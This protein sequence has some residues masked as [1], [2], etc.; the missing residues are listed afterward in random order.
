[1]PNSFWHRGAFALLAVTLVTEPAVAELKHM[2][3]GVYGTRNV[4]RGSRAIIEVSQGWFDLVDYTPRLD[5]SRLDAPGHTF[6]ENRSTRVFTTVAHPEPLTSNRVVA[7]CDII[8]STFRVVYRPEDCST[9]RRLALKHAGVGVQRIGVWQSHAHVVIDPVIRNLPSG[10]TATITCGTAVNC[11]PG[12]SRYPGKIYYFRGGQ[13][14]YLDFQVS[15][16]APTGSYVMTLVLEPEGDTRKEVRIPLRISALSPIKLSTPSTAPAIPNLSQWESTMLRLAAKWCNLSNPTA[17]MAFGVDSQVWYYDGAQVY[18]EVADYTRNSAWEACALNIA[19]QYRDYA[20]GAQ[21]KLPGFRVFTA[22]LAMAYRRTGDPSY[23]RAVELLALN[24]LYATGGFVRDDG[25]RETAYALRAM[26]DYEKLTGVRSP[27][28]ARSV[29]LLLGM[30][31]QRFVSNTYIYQQTFMS[32]LGMRALIEY[33]ELTKDPRIPRAIKTALDWI[34]AN[35]RDPISNWLYTN[36]DP[37]GARCDYGCKGTSPASNDL[38][39][40]T[41]P[42]Y[43][44]YWSITNSATDRARADE[45]FARALDRDISYSGKIFSQNYTWSFQHVRWRSLLAGSVR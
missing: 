39:N 11:W 31:D 37:L 22:G 1:M 24:G 35:C 25:M 3:V 40:L 32:G 14:I 16:T 12:G 43:A 13:S 42:A 18:F 30:F 2:V 34:W 45:L 23:L 41:A 38:I 15:P 27:H 29:D 20:I 26:I 36:P 10:V 5:T 19:S 4:T 28:M 44:W 21:G 6:T 8:G 17:K 9:S 7:V 33:W